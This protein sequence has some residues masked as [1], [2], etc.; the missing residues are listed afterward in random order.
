MTKSIIIRDAHEHNLNHVDLTIPRDSIVVVTGVSGS[1]KSSLAFD[2]VFQEGQRRFV[3]SLSAYARQFIGRMKRPDV[4]SVRGI[5]PTI[6][7]DQKTVNRNPRSTV[8]TVVEILDHYRLL[9]ARLGLPHCPKCGRVIKAQSVDQIVDNLYVSD[10]DR[11]ITVM[12]PIVQDRKGEYRKEL[13]ELRENGFVR[14]RV[15]CKIYRIEDV[16]PLVR[17]EKHTIEAVIDRTELS[18]K[19]M[20]RVREAIEGALKLTEGKLVSFLFGDGG[21][22]GEGEYRLQGTLLA[23]PKCNISIPELEPRFFSF[24]DPKGRCPLC[25]GLGESCEFDENLVVPD[26]SLSINQ[27]ALACQKK[28][29]G[30]VIFSDFGWKDLRIIAHEMKFSMDTPWCK[31]KQA[32]QKAVLYGTPSGSMRGVITVMQELWD[33]WHI[34]HFRKYM[35]IGVCPE[36][37]GRRINPIAQAVDFHGHNICEMTDWSIEK[38]VEFFDSLKLSE[39]ELHIGREIF[40]EIRG[41]LGFL[42]AVGLGYLTISRKAATLSGGEA[43]RIRLAGAVGAGLQGVLYVMD[44]P[45]IGLHPRDNDRLLEMLKK[46]RSQGNSLIVVEHDEDT[47]R[48]ADYIVDVGPGAGVEGGRI[49]A[50]GT[51]EELEKNKSSITGAYLSGRKSIEVPKQRL[52]VTAETPKLKVV[53]ASENNLKNIDV[54]IPLGGAFTV[55]TGV[56]GSGKSTL[57]NQILRKELARQLNGAEELPGK[58]ER[59]EGVENLDKVIEIDQTPIGRTPRSNPATYTKIWD[60]I[61]DLYAG[62]SES[63]VRGYTKSRYSFNVKGGRCEACEGAGVKVVDMHILPSVQVTCEVC[64]GKRFNEAT[65]EVYFNGKN[66][67]D[68]LEMSI[69]EA[70]EFFKNIPKIAGPL[71]LLKE[72]GLGYLRLGQPSTTLSGGE[73]QRVKIASELRRPGTGKTLYLLDEPTTGLHFEDIRKLLECLNRLRSLGNSVVVIEHNLDVIKCADW[74]VDLGPDAGVNGGRVIATGAPETIAKSKKSETGKYLAKVLN[75][76]PLTT[77]HQPPTTNNQKPS[78]DYSLN[79]EVRGA[80]KHNLKNIDVTIPRHKLTVITGVSG[81]GKSSL[82][83]HTLFSEGQRRF[84]ETLST[85]ARRFLGR[86]DRGSIDSISGLAPAIAI[87][88]KSASKSPRS[89]VATLTEIYDYFR[90]FWARVGTPHCLHCGR[91]IDSYAVSQLVTMAFEKSIGSMVTVLAPFEIKDVLTLSKILVEKGYRKVFMGKKMVELPLP[92]VPTR[93]KEL[94]AVVDQVVIKEENRTRL[95][96]AFERAY[97]DGGGILQVDF[98]GANWNGLGNNRLVASEKPGCPRCGWYMDSALNPKHFS[99]NTHWGACETCLG[100]GHLRTG[101]IC[102]DCGGERLKPEYLAVRIGKKNIMDVNHLSIDEARDWFAELKFDGEKNAEGK[103]RVA[104]PLLREIIGRLDFLKSVGLGYIGLDRAGDTLSGGESQRIRLASQIGS[105]LEGVLYVL[106]EPTVGLH[107]SDTNKLLETLR[108]LRDLGNTLVVVEHDMNMMRSADHIIDMGPAAG[109]F[110][111]CVVAEGSPELLS[112]PYALQQFPQSETVKYL[113]RSIP[114]ANEVAAK[115]ITDSTEFYEFK[116]LSANNLKNL[117]VK[118]PK[119]AVSVVCGVS[120]SGKSSLVMNEIY[121]A[122]CRKFQARGS[123]KKSGQAMLVD[124]SPI[125]GTPRSTPASFTGV[126]DDIRA[127]F[128]KLEQ[129][130]VKGFDYGRFS[131]NL[132]RGRCPVCEGRGAI[133]VEM[134]FLSDVW[135]TCEACGGKRYNQETLT[136]TFK[137]K[138]I[139]DVLDMRVAEACEFFKDQPKILPKLEA[140]RD[141]GL[142]YVRLGQSVTTLSGGENQRLKLA[143]ELARKTNGETVY[144]LDEPTTGLHLKDIQV[145]WNLLRRLSARG[146]TVIVIE[147][148]PDIIRLADW[149]VELGPVGGASGGYLL[150]MG[151]NE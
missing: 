39:R 41:R 49:M 23:C 126:L 61:R 91:P 97:R 36:C 37:S 25:K 83:F 53:G 84:V 135:E 11:Q 10:V 148:H 150:N 58:F 26:K 117:S 114:M 31:L 146:D 17:Y 66:I 86:P 77:N 34:Y 15:D 96:E 51:V 120:G 145:L 64:G 112:K 103:E 107:E 129:S 104:A 80:R 99:F 72:V 100:L 50:A 44:E 110:G 134:H 22:N 63:K 78:S 137:G 32:Q 1:G 82:A 139:A 7:I 127:L 116:N 8:G 121:P 14:A 18:R 133:S 67:Y 142:P 93:E 147:H 70:H 136:V 54:E 144:L 132:A 128:S 65:C 5:S 19:N 6:S 94:L 24:N 119:G 140:L 115:P 106:D 89:T 29:T 98:E 40:K 108:R 124:Q 68:V 151:K 56:S 38:S 28:D 48:H 92:K 42:Q 69:D 20:S 90:I 13:L 76:Q 149:K 16:P 105:G 95:V 118:F 60:D 138:N 57:V 131:Y 125:S 52:K 4:E 9:F 143:A 75:R 130:K 101:K 123:K 27:G 2:T 47:M 74:I 43:Q 46:L 33:L 141:V 71:A 81:S 88:Q 122:L 111:G 62:L 79:I 113:T 102:P 73:A 45:S 87:D 12:A 35:Q 59:L 55:V 3:E 109:E 85:Y 21:T 30:D